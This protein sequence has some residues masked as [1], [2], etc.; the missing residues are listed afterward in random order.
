MATLSTTTASAIGSISGPS[1]GDAYFVT[2]SG[3]LAVY[4]GSAFNLTNY[5]TTYNSG[6]DEI[7]KYCSMTDGTND[8]WTKASPSSALQIDPWA[9]SGAKNLT[10]LAWV[11]LDEN[12]DDNGLEGVFAVGAYATGKNRGMQI[13]NNKVGYY[14]YGQTQ[15]KADTEIT[16]GTWNFV[17]Y[18]L[19]AS[20][21]ATIFY[22]N[23]SADGTATAGGVEIDSW[24][25]ASIADL[26]ASDTPRHPF[27]GLID[28]VGIWDDILTAAEITALYNGG[29]AAR[30]DANH[31]NYVSS[32]N[33]QGWWKMGDA[34][35]G[36]GTTI[37]DSS[38][39]SNHMTAVNDAYIINAHAPSKI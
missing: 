8:L 32:A 23:G 29:Y 12:A 24:D 28:Q 30:Y 36:T 38:T 13:S 7:S 18:T 22:T 37:T 19:Q 15:I 16:S 20:D 31:G 2:D 6:A 17:G 21:K 9:S 26:H 34:D 27:T 3:Q 33:L 35:S 10:I 5:N 39:N 14:S 25:Y 11:N 1:T 4:N